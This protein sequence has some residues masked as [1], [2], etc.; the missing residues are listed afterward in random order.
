MPHLCKVSQRRFYGISSSIRIPE[1]AV[2]RFRRP[3]KTGRH[4]PERLVD[5]LWNGWTA[6]I[7]IDGRHG[8][9]Y[10][11]QTTFWQPVHLEEWKGPQQ[12]ETGSIWS[13]KGITRKRY[14]LISARMTFFGQ[15]RAAAPTPAPD[16]PTTAE[17]ARADR[18]AVTMRKSWRQRP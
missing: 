8:P 18:P 14:W 3:G 6:S 16:M 11:L 4:A 2:H 12:G 10:A 13:T 17:A 9:D 7:G 1:H 5:M 15:D